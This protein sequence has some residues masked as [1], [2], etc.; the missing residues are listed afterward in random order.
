MPNGRGTVD[1]MYCRHH[2]FVGSSDR[3]REAFCDQ[4][5]LTLPREEF[6][7]ENLICTD[8]EEDYVRQK[9]PPRLTLRSF[10]KPGVLYA[11]FYNDEARPHLYRPVR[12]L[13]EGK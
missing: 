10:L 9:H 2:R 6:G 1:C 4:W 12:E 8:Y 5:N 3:D 7:T 11:F 13:D